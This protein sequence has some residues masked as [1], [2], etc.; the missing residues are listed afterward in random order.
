MQLTIP[1]DD[2]SSCPSDIFFMNVIPVTP[3][4]ARPPNFLHN[5]ISWHQSTSLYRSI[6]ENNQVLRVVMR[7]I[8][9]QKDEML[10]E[11]NVSH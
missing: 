5:K 11:E 9:G 8:K 4:K 7:R 10:E 2:K 3:N 1:S 6:I